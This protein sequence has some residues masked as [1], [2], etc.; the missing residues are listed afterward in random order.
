VAHGT[1]P[2]RNLS[3]WARIEHGMRSPAA[4]PSAV[5]RLTA[6]A[7]VGA[8]LL[9][10][11]AACSPPEVRV[12]EDETTVEVEVGTEIEVA[13][14]ENASVGDRW[15]VRLEPDGSVAELVG[16]THEGDCTD[17]VTGCGGTRVFHVDATGEGTT[18]LELYNCWRCSAEG[19]PSPDDVA[20]GLAR[21]YV[22]TIIVEG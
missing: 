22:L 12:G 11:S 16:S 14:P 20:A 15:D 9:L 19:E 18:T 5:R 2:A 3:A 17:D 7:V 1:V 21:P 4:L 13:L 8:S 10:G 6:T